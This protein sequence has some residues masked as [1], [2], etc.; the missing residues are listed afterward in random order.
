MVC[1]GV[2]LEE[3]TASQYIRWRQNSAPGA[4]LRFCYVEA[5]P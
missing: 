1:C 3:E 5:A 2:P 4:C